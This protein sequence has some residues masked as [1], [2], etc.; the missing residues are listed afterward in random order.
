VCTGKGVPVIWICQLHET[1]RYRNPIQIQQTACFHFSSCT[2]V[3]PYDRL[4]WWMKGF[5]I[6]YCK[7]TQIQL[8]STVMSLVCGRMTVSTAIGD[9]ENYC[10]AGKHMNAVKCFFNILQSY[11]FSFKCLLVGWEFWLLRYQTTRSL[12]HITLTFLKTC[13]FVHCVEIWYRSLYLYGQYKDTDLDWVIL[14]NSSAYIWFFSF[15]QARVYGTPYEA[16]PAAGQ[17][18]FKASNLTGLWMGWTEDA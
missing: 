16:N 10:I 6:I 14:H 15:L 17:S 18:S 13:S 4:Y 2:G 9:W 3:Y 1:N 12:P 7:M 11:K 8:T 5:R